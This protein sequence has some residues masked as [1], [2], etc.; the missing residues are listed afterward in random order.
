M[1]QIDGSTSREDAHPHDAGPAPGTTTPM[2]RA[3][4]ISY[5]ALILFSAAH[6]VRE[7]ES[8]LLPNPLP[9]ASAHAEQEGPFTALPSATPD[10][11]PVVYQ[12]PEQSLAPATRMTPAPLTVLPWA[13]APCNSRP[14][15]AQQSRRTPEPGS[16]EVASLNPGASGYTRV[17]PRTGVATRSLARKPANR[18]PRRMP[19]HPRAS[20]LHW[21]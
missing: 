3:F 19:G 10:L 4:W 15:D 8:E 1:D 5:S 16:M 20:S 21:P 18:A 6:W 2:Q 14:P 11:R 13:D 17:G 9:T 12:S 7:P